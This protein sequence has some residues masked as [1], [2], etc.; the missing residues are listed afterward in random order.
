[1]E[2]IRKSLQLRINLI[3]FNDDVIKYYV[4]EVYLHIRN[5]KVCSIVSML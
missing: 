4:M 1:M 5:T 3:Q 2:R